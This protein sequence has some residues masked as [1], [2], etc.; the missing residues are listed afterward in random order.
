MS[1]RVALVGYGSA[2]RGIHRPLLA[3]A[4]ASPMVVVTGNAERAAQVAAELPAARVVPDL[5]AALALGIDL[6]VIASPSGVH[7]VNALACIEAGV[8]AVVDKPLGT[9]AR[10]AADVVDRAATRGVPLTV[11]QNRRW[12]AE[13]RTLARLLG[14]GAL[15]DVH[16]FERRWERWR[17]VPKN[18]WRENAPAADGGGILLDLGPHLVDLAL[19]LFGPVRAVYAETAAWTTAAEDDAFLALEHAG[20]VRSHLAASS[21]AGAPGPRTRVLGSAGAY[22][23]TGFESEPH[24]FGGFDDAPGC[25]GWLVAGDV[26]TP[27]ATQPGGPAEF[28]PAVLAALALADPAARQVAMP[29]DPADAVATAQVL[30]AARTSA[31]Q[32]RVVELTPPL[33]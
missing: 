16:R 24:A 17:P 10:Q 19:H 23:V 13:N 15:G 8:A 18:R 22:V 25:T 1:L 30:D 20:G 5:D 12:D 7:G 14:Q 6:A 28:Y 4:G 9:G 21:V 2:G 31:A 29:V 33:A 3:A 11:F 32:R 26:R 27:V